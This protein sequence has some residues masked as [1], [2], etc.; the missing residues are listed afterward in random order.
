MMDV[1]QRSPDQAQVAFLCAHPELAGKEA[2]G[3]HDDVATRSASRQAP[4]SMP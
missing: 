1:V 2:A 4:V 3:R